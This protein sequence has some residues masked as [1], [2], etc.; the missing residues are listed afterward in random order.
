MQKMSSDYSIS[1][2]SDCNYDSGN[3]DLFSI[4]MLSFVIFVCLLVYFKSDED[5][6]EYPEWYHLDCFF[7]T[8]LP[9]TEAAF[10]GFA[11]LRY[12]DQMT[13]TEKI[14]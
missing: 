14:G 3:Y 13:I 11:L 4:V 6:F 5:D 7:K 12:K 9:L 8:R 10:D 2:C 1:C